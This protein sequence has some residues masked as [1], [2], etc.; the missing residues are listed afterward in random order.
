M[1]TV[2]S[3][4][5]HTRRRVNGGQDWIRTNED[6]SQQIYSLPRL[7]TSVPTHDARLRVRRGFK[8]HASD[9]KGF[10]VPRPENFS[11]TDVFAPAPGVCHGHA[12]S[13]SPLLAVILD[14]DLLLSSLVF[15]LL[16]IGLVIAGFKIFDI[17]TPGNLQEEIVE[18]KNLAAAILAASVVIGICIV[19]AAAI[20]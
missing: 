10:T 13:I 12:M 15:G 6:V 7:A 8:Y 9:C 16:G 19:V 1:D 11:R 4:H 14:E 5:G 18:K 17:L 2:R 20:G 3:L